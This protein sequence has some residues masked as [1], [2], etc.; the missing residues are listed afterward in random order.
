[1]PFNKDY[2]VSRIYSTLVSKVINTATNFRYSCCFTKL[3]DLNDCTDCKDCSSKDILAS[4]TT[5][6]VQEL[7]E[8][9]ET[10]F[11]IK[12][13]WSGLD[14]VK[15]IYIDDTKVLC[16]V[17]T[18]LNQKEIITTRERLKL[19]STLGVAWIPSS[20]PEHGIAVK[21]LS[22]KEIEVLCSPTTYHYYNKKF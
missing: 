22:D 19:T 15:S 17:V 6:D 13:G 10:L 4:T 5:D 11:C 20:V 3:P 9:G 12:D 21:S 18:D 8:E 16:F 14:K 7:F 2:R 1:M